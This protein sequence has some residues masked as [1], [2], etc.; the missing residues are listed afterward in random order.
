MLISRDLYHS[1]WTNFNKGD[2]HENSIFS[3]EPEKWHKFFGPDTVTEVLDNS[4]LRGELN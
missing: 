2:I 3:R 4:I 1:I